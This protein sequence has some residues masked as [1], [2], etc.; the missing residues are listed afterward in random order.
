MSQYFFIGDKK[1][2][3]DSFQW[4]PNLISAAQLKMNIV[5][6]LLTFTNV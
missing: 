3:G 5:F 4:I 2:S 1:G 6:L